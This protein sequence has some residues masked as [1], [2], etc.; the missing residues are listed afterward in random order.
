MASVAQRLYEEVEE[1]DDSDLV[2]ET[3]IPHRVA[4]DGEAGAAFSYAIS[5]H[6]KALEELAEYDR[7]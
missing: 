7:S 2:L 6:R 3:P 4:S 5:K 1:L